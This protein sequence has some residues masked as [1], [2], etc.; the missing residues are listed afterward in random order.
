MDNELGIIG[1]KK[2]K[3]SEKI[4]DNIILEIIP[5]YFL[6]S[7]IVTTCFFCPDINTIIGIIITVVTFI[8]CV[9]F[10]LIEIKNNKNEKNNY[11]YVYFKDKF[12][13]SDYYN[14]NNYFDECINCILENNIK[15][16]KNNDNDYYFTDFKIYDD[17]RMNIYNKLKNQYESI[18]F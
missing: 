5:I 6:S 13:L 2:I 9:I 10:T 4:T 11:L 17:E 18:N 12:A 16:I 14:S 8:F 15:P 7:L 1:Y 3:K